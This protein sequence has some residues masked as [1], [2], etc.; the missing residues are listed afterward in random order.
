VS[1]IL[2]VVHFVKSEANPV[3]ASNAGAIPALLLTFFDHSCLNG[4]IFFV[5]VASHRM[6]LCSV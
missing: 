3:D 4:T 5:A 6:Q 2:F 1:P